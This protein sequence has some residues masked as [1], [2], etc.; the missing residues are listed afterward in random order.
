VSGTVFAILGSHWSA[1]MK[2]LQDLLQTHKF[3][4]TYTPFGNEVEIQLPEGLPSYTLPSRSD[5]DSSEVAKRVMEEAGTKKTCLLI[6]G[7]AFDT[8]GTRHG[9]GGGWYD[10]FLSQLPKAWTRIGVCRGD[11]FSSTPLIRES[12]D[13]PMDYVCVGDVLH[14]TNAR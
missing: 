11:Q 13:E 10:R 14:V 5:I 2:E 3:C 7:T 12:W 9:R 1:D 6:P 8:T 4:V